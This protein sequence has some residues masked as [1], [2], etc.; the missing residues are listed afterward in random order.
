MCPTGCVSNSS[1][2]SCGSSCTACSTPSNGSPTCNGT[3]CGVSCNNGYHVCGT[4]CL[5]NTSVDSC[6]SSCTACSTPSNGSPTCNGTACG[7]SCNNGYHACGSS[8]AIN[9]STDSC[10]SS[11]SACSPPSNASPT[12][13]GTA[14]G[15]TCNNGYHLCGSGSSSTCASNTSI[16]SCGSSCNA[17]PP[18]GLANGT[19]TCNGTSCGVGCLS[20]YGLCLNGNGTTNSCSRTTFDFNDGTTQGWM[21]TNA[22]TF[23]T[24]TS[25]RRGTSGASL[26][27]EIVK[28][29]ETVYWGVHFPLCSSSSMNLLGKTV[30]AWVYIEGDAFPS[31]GAL[32]DMGILITNT[33][34]MSGSGASATPVRNQWFQ[35]SATVSL[36][37]AQTAAQ[38]DIALYLSCDTQWLGAVYVDDVT[39]GG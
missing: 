27:Y 23:S 32:H 7:I 19:A 3:A 24:S 30:S 11:C 20:G 21:N 38:V 12:C 35:V 15:F 28:F 33:S 14:C 8:C 18:P 9:T 36:S 5:S 1:V 2:D 13:N 39:I 29:S 26:K 34:G 10:G 6:G 31:C 37:A 25:I 4:A 17:C 22:G 16:N